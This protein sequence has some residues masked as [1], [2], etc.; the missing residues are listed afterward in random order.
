MLQIAPAK[1]WY[2]VNWNCKL[3]TILIGLL[4]Q[5]KSNVGVYGEW[6]TGVCSRVEKQLT[7]HVEI[8]KPVCFVASSGNSEILKKTLEG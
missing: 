6:K 3:S 1:K 4:T 8:V 5:I 7:Y 2:S